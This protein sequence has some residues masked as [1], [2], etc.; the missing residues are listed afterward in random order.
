MA[1]SCSRSKAAALCLSAVSLGLCLWGIIELFGG[2]RPEKVSLVSI[3][4][5]C[6]NVGCVAIHAEIPLEV[7]FYNRSEST[8]Q[9]V[10]MAE[11]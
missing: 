1:F 8:A 10:G 2:P 6:H 7:T 3:D 11:L 9:V 5:A 4:P